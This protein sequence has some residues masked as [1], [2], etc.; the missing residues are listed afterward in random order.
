MIWPSSYLNTVV[1]F[2]ENP[3]IA[4]YSLLPDNPL[5]QRIQGWT[6]FSF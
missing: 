2:D 1:N 6:D 4:G 5:C 3:Y